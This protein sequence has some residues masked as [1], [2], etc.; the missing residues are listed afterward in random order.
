MRDR[1]RGRSGLDIAPDRRYWAFNSDKKKKRRIPALDGYLN[2][3]WSGMVAR[4]P[5][6]QQTSQHERSLTV[7]G[8]FIQRFYFDDSIINDNRIKFVVIDN[9]RPRND[10]PQ[11]G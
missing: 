10:V 9:T 8:E 11:N 5:T 1:A 3:D 4:Q 6:K 7:A 2:D